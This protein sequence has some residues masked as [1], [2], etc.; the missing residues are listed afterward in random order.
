MKLKKEMI[1]IASDHAG[2]RMKEKLKRFLDRKG[3]EIKDLGAVKYI[4]NDDYPD[5]ALK[6]AKKIS[7]TEGRGILICG[8]GHGMNIA[9]NKTKGI[10]ASIVWNKKSAKYA[11]SHTNINLVSLPA[12]L[13]SQGEAEKIVMVWLKTKFSKEKRH[14][15]RINKIKRIEKR[16][17]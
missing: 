12:R 9:A 5:Y 16:L 8:A 7:K 3:Y 4:K 14:L 15:N 13:I 1:Y 2:F 6:L 11:K 17:K 10:R